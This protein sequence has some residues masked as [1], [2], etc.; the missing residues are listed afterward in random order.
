[1]S[2]YVSEL[3]IKMIYNELNKE[4]KEDIDDN[5]EILS[6]ICINVRKPNLKVFFF[7]SVTGNVASYSHNPI[8][9]WL[10]RGRTENVRRR[11]AF[12]NI[13][14]HVRSFLSSIIIVGGHRKTSMGPVGIWRNERLNWVRGSK[15]F[16]LTCVKAESGAFS[17]ET[18]AR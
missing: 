18:I 8:G 6:S 15:C 14:V 9:R 12:F 3:I 17:R 5:S 4:K 1:M 11:E 2:K 10:P 16:L 7:R 13:Q